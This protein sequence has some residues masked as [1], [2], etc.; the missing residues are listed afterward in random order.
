MSSRPYGSRVDSCEW[1]MGSITAACVA[2]LLDRYLRQHVYKTL[3]KEEA[4]AMPEVCKPYLTTKKHYAIVALMA[5][6]GYLFLH[7]TV[8]SMRR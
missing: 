1:F 7:C 2:V 3:N 8:R 6:I 5:A 4:E